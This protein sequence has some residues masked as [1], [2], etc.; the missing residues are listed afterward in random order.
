M[1]NAAVHQKS[2]KYSFQES[3]D[4]NDDKNNKTTEST[5]KILSDEEISAKLSPIIQDALAWQGYRHKALQ[6]PINFFSVGLPYGVLFA[7]IFNSFAIGILF[8]VILFVMSV[9]TMILANLD[10]GKGV[11]LEMIVKD[12]NYVVTRFEAMKKKYLLGSITSFILLQSLP[13][14]ILVDPTNA[15]VNLF[16]SYTKFIIIG[17]MITYPIAYHFF[18]KS[19]GQM[20]AY[21]AGKIPIAWEQKIVRYTNVIRESLLKYDIEQNNKDLLLNEIFK[22]HSEVEKW[23]FEVNKKTSAIKGLIASSMFLL[24]AIFTICTGVLQ[25]DKTNNDGFKVT[26]M[27]LFACLMLLSFIIFMKMYTAPSVVWNRETKAL[28]SDP[29]LAYRIEEMFGK[30]QFKQLL[31]NH[32]LKAQRLLGLQGTT[33]RLFKIAGTVGSIFGIV[34]YFLIREEL[35]TLM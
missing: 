34:A 20:G 14:L 16:G 33:D 8:G 2:S 35:R 4:N 25:L 15:N 30:N 17:N 10:Y 26:V 24:A 29:R 11:F 1:S 23:A 18:R 9:V 31:D 3:N 6:I 13:F 12:E 5:R 21:F 19:S 32:E 7:C 22:M 27:G 28:L